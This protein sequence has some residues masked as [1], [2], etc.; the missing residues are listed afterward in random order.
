MQFR[1][2]HAYDGVTFPEY[3]T[4]HFDEAFNASLCEATKLRREVLKLERTPERIIRHVRIEPAREIP[5]PVAKVLGGKKFSYVEELEYELG[6]GRGRWRTIPN[7]MPEKIDSQGTLE[8]VATTNGVKRV[9]AGDIKVSV[10]GLGGL[11]EKFVVSDVEKSYE[12]A[13][14]FTR[15]YLRE[16]AKG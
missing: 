14:E 9:V 8:L 16:R 4:I 6:K 5:G 10:F 2:E 7:I 13:A 1:V 3:E 12:A 15:R 11:I